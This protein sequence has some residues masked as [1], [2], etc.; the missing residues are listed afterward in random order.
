MEIRCGKLQYMMAVRLQSTCDGLLTFFLTMLTH[1][2][3][4]QLIALP[5]NRLVS[6][7]GNI[8]KKG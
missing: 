7:K 6:N 8:A 4:S 1:I 2:E 3:T 5:I